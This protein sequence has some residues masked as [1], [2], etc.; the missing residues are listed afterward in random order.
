MF[1]LKYISFP[2]IFLFEYE[3]AFYPNSRARSDHAMGLNQIPIV[4]SDPI[5]G[6]ILLDSTDINLLAYNATGIMKVIFF[7]Q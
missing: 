6:I 7:V 3:L 2:A 5:I 4:S 1:L